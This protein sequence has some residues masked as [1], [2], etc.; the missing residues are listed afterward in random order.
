ML[1]DAFISGLMQVLSWPAFGFLLIGA[2]VGFVVGILPGL[3]GLSTLALM[4]PFVWTIKEPIS[5]FSFL[6]GMHAITGTTGDITSI[7]FGIPGEG[8]AA[9]T[10]IDGYP[11]TKKGEAGRALGAALMSSLVAGLEGAIILAISIPIMRPL[12]LFFA[13]PELFMLAILGITFIVSLSG[14]SLLKGLLAAGIGLMLATIGVDPQTGALR[15]TLGTFYLWDGL[16]LIPVVIG[17]FAIPEIVDLAVRGTSIVEDKV[18]KLEGVMEGVKDTFRHFWLTMRC[19]LI[20]VL[21]GALPGLGGGVSQW[22]AYGHAVQSSKDQSRFGKG[23]V[24]GVLGPGA[25]NNSKEGGN[26]IPTV[27]FG[28]PGSASMAI[29]LGAFLL[30]GL[31]PG[32]DMLTKHLDVTFAMV[33]ILVIANIITAGVAFL[34]LNQ[35]VKIT[36]VRGGILIPFLLMFIFLGAFTAHN[37]LNDIVVTIIFGLLGYFMVL[38]EWPRPPFVLGLVLGRIAEN[39]LWISNSAYGVSWLLHPAIIVIFIMIVTTLG[40]S[41]FNANKRKK[42]ASSY[43]SGTSE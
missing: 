21:I 17:L 28:I 29:L 34:F 26:L 9:A 8:T 35:L 27:A 11:M 24:E 36:F 14:D 2:A 25:A 32:P 4:L 40:Y 41:I 38:F 3:G 19:G 43:E 5:A 16:S 23:A 30:V 39:N 10:I 31:Q 15:Y 6:L 37:S 7:L 18:E 33:W 22:L 20:G 13:S 12:V 42:S 1:F